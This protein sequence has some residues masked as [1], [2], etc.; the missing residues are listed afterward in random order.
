MK[1]KLMKK[2]QQGFAMLEVMLAILVIAIASF[3]VYKLYNSASNSS[4]INGLESVVSQVKKGVDQYAINNY[5]PAEFDDLKKS[6]YISEGVF[7]A[8]EG[9]FNAPYTVTYTK[10]NDV[11]QFQLTI[12]N[13]PKDSVWQFAQHM[14]GMADVVYRGAQIDGSTATAPAFAG[15][16]DIDL[17]FPKGS[18][19][20]PD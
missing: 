5:A 17:Y 18:Y 1:T 14:L 9:K 15:L 20:K 8:T 19:K 7:S 10:G 11:S 6:G 13:L 12:K 4:K 3:G 16:N 2:R